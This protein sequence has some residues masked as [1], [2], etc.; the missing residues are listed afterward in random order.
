MR[1]L[2]SSL[3]AVAVLLLSVSGTACAVSSEQ[4]APTKEHRDAARLVTQLIARAHYQPGDLDDGLSERILERFLERLDPNRV[5]L[6]EADVAE[7]MANR[8][9]V[10]EWLREAR[11]E[12]A[13]SVFRTY[14][15]RMTKYLNFALDLLQRDFDFD[16]EE[17]YE[18]DRS[19]AP[20]AKSEDELKELWRKRV[21][22]DMLTLR[23]QEME[24]AEILEV[25]DKRYNS[26]IKRASQFDQNEVFE[27]F[28][29]AY[30]TSI[31][32]HTAYMSPRS[33]ESFQIR[34]NLSLEGI[35]ARLQS[36]DD[37]TL[38]RDIVAGGPADKSGELQPGDRITGVGQG[39]SGDV[40]DVVGMRLADVVDLIRGPKGSTVRLR[41]LPEAEGLKG[42]HKDIALVRDEIRLE[43]QAAKSSVIDVP[44][45]KGTQQIGVIRIPTFYTDTRRRGERDNAY[46][47]TSHD[48]REL[49]N[50]MQADGDGI[51]GLV[52][53]LRGNGG[54]A[55]VE[56]IKLTGLFIESGPVVQV[57]ESR[58][59][60]EVHR[61][62][63]PSIAYSGPLVV[64]VNGFSASASEIFAAAIQDYGRGLIVGEKTHGKGTVQSLVDLDQYVSEA[65]NGLGH[66]KLTTAQFF[67]INGDGTQIR[68]VTPDIEFQVTPYADEFGESSLDNALPWQSVPA[69]NFERFPVVISALDDVRS[70]HAQ[71]IASDEEFQKIAREAAK[72]REERDDSR[73]PL[74]ESARKDELEDE[75]EEDEEES[76]EAD[77][78][79]ADAVLEEAAH[80]LADVIDVDA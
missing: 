67:R 41:V 77:E 4:L 64:L 58:G 22:N 18:V 24:P 47:S 61:D 32:P 45:E 72:R 2:P 80:I 30:A 76:A 10:D 55:L 23:L 7:V 75:P 54:G 1:K 43:D 40:T 12:P 28:M 52:V 25:L 46:R 20:W 51:D 69:A 3:A 33:S 79:I 68:G 9:G 48:V 57:R 19:E 15:E 49:V 16:L 70:R 14:R 65:G 62:P 37:Y 29:N 66:L 8:Y 17:Y 6:T 63:D 59:G 27:L 26:L 21:K 56:A 73:L 38:V 53:D 5:Y 35:G 71:R 13:F 74:K 50:E 36:E 60:I 78:D 42:T 34:M 11:L 39:E 44:T 31:E